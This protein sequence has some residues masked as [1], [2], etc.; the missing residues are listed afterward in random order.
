M[1]SLPRS[2]GLW[3]TALLALAVQA[4]AAPAQPAAADARFEALGARFITE[5]GRYSPVNA[6]GLGD[7]RF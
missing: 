4:Q 1:R 6:T 3:L 2:L 5:F 7:H